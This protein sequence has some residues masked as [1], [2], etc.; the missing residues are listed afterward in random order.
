MPDQ[1]LTFNFIQQKVQTVYLFIMV[2]FSDHFEKKCIFLNCW[3][4]VNAYKQLKEPRGGLQTSLLCFLLVL[5]REERIIFE[6]D[7]GRSL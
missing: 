4:Y 2:S 1:K 7:A 3:N 6:A 5:L